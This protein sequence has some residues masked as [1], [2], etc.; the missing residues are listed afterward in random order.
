[1]KILAEVRLRHKFRVIGYVVMPE[2]V[3]LLISEPAS[4]NPSKVLQVLKQKVSR[5]LRGKPK[6]QI[7]GQLL[8]GFGGNEAEEDAFWQRRFYD[9]N[10]WNALKVREKLDYMHANPVMRGLVEHPKD[11]PWS[12]WS[13]YAVGETGLLRIDTMESMDGSSTGR[14]RKSQNPHP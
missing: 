7:P 2:H 1:V 8:L 13:H 10:V 3:H 9:F 4:G 6:R 11:W 12:S 5:A 14:E